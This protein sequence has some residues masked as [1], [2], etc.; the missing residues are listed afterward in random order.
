MRRSD[1]PHKTAK[2]SSKLKPL[3]VL[4]LCAANAVPRGAHNAWNLLRCL[5]FQVHALRGFRVSVS[6]H[7]IQLPELQR[8]GALINALT[9]LIFL[10]NNRSAV[11]WGGGHA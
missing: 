11:R 1:V 2:R 10:A 3:S 6:G 9:L 5:P 7:L 4:K 8:W